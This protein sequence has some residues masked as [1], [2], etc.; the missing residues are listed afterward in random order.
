[1]QI[2]DKLEENNSFQARI[3]DQIFLGELFRYELEVLDGGENLT[4]STRD[5]LVNGSLI[6][7]KINPEGMEIFPC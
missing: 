2:I 5:T 4:F 7:I 1:M 3:R 6:S